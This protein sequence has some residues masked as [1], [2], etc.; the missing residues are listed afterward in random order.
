MTSQAHDIFYENPSQPSASHRQPQQQQ[1]QQQQQQ[2]PI[3]RQQSRPFDAYGTMPPPSLYQNDDHSVQSY[4]PR[5][6]DNRMNATLGSGYQGYDAWGPIS[7][8]NA[9]NNSHATLGAA[10]RRNPLNNNNR[11]A[12]A[13][14][15]SVSL[16]FCSTYTLML[17]TMIVYFVKS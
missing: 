13:G 1:P 9:Q 3:Q 12:R 6:P 7:F 8:A 4:L 15:P 16:L 10:T 2:H 11:N 5:Y 17:E 14:L